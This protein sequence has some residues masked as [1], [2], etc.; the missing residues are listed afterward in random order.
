MSF[1]QLKLDT[2]NLAQ[3][4]VVH[5]KYLLWDDELSP[6]RHDEDHVTHLFNFWV[7]VIY[8]EW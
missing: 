3:L 6:K 7:Q 1:K 4:L 2:S 8:L 5:V